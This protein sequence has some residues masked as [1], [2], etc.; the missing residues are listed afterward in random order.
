MSKTRPRHH[1]IVGQ[2]VLDYARS[3]ELPGDDLQHRTVVQARLATLVAQAQ[4]WRQPWRAET[5]EAWRRRTAALTLLRAAKA[6]N[7]IRLIVR[8]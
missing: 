5:A 2:F 6:S 8:R 4:T 1:V 3:P 7:A